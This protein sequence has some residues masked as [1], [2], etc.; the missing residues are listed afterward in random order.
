MNAP[1]STTEGLTIGQN[2]ISEAKTTTQLFRIKMTDKETADIIPGQK[3][4]EEYY[5]VY[6]GT[7]REQ[8]QSI[9]SKTGKDVSIDDISPIESTNLSEKHT[10]MAGS[11]LRRAKILKKP[12]RAFAMA[13]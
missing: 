3:T 12:L 8:I 5:I 1:K 7:G 10:S 11:A 2:R 9:L 13:A 4:P 6:A